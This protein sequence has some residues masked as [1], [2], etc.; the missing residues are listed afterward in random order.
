MKPLFTKPEFQR[1]ADIVYDTMQPTLQHQW[2]LLAKRTGC[3]V[4]VK[5]ENHT[6]TGAF[7]IRGGL[8][9]MRLRR[10]SGKAGG[11]VSATRGNHGQ[12]LA[13]AGK[14]EGI[15]VTIFAPRGNS[16]EKNAAMRAQGAELI[17]AGEDFDEAA[18]LARDYASEH[19]LEMMPSFMAE[20]AMGVSTYGRELF[21]AV[22]NS[23]DVLD[24]VYVPI[25]LGSGICSLI[26]QRDMLGLKT[27]IVGVVST[28][29]NTYA[30]SIANGQP[31][32]TNSARTFADGVA[33]RMPDPLAL[34]IISN[35]AERIVE[36]TDKEVANAMRAYYTDTHNLAEGAGAASLAALTQ[37]KDRMA[38]KSVAI[39]LTGGNIDQSYYKAV[40]DGGVPEV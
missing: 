24:T 23:G 29:A 10:E 21:D 12:S 38:G 36:V 1:A 3:N 16:V 18:G 31:V 25:G 2:P 30:L 32:P 7:K 20:L 9:Y 6:P 11:I 5:H 22:K 33:V 19:D 13:T 34:E 40:L 15:P 35:G 28:E 17:E 27:K 4:W 39:I 37:E 8:V 14:R 26:T